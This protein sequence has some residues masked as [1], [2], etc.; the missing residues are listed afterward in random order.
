MP[1][2]PAT[3]PLPTYDDWGHKGV[4][5]FSTPVEIAHF[6]ATH[7][8]GFDLFALL[9]EL[10]QVAENRKF[11]WTAIR[12]RIMDSGNLRIEHTF[13]DAQDDEPLSLIRTLHA[14]LPRRASHEEMILPPRLQG[15][16][17][18]RELIAPYYRQYQQAAVELISINAS[19]SGGGYAWAKYGFAAI[20]QAD[21]M[22]ILDAAPGRNISPAQIA[23]LCEDVATFYAQGVAPFPLETWARLPFGKKLLTG[24]TWKGILDLRNPVQVQIFEAYLY[25]R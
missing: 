22:H 15:Q 25:A 3:T 10:A 17:L 1:T 24:T 12:V 23:E 11:E 7:F 19:L 4:S 16:G 21:V 13:D 5:W 9:T 6:L 14:N 20:L 2:P 18:S 8:A